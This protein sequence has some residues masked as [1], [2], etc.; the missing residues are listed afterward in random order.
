VD[1]KYL[2][3]PLRAA[4]GR[5]AA[6]LMLFRQKTSPDFQPN[7][8]TALK[9]IVAQISSAVLEPLIPAPPAR[10]EVKPEVKAVVAAQKPVAE[11][12]MPLD[13]RLRA[14]L[15]AGAFD[16]YAQP[17]AALHGAPRGGRFEV[18]VRMRD[19]DT[20]RMPRS[21]FGVA[22]A[23]GLLPDLDRCV[24]RQALQTLGSKRALLE[25]RGWEFSIN[26]SGQ[27]LLVDRFGE[28][29]EAQLTRSSVAPK[30]L[31]FEIAESSA[32]EHRYATEHLAARLR[33]LGCRLALDN[34]CAG[35][36]TFGPIRRWPVSCLKIDA[37]L[38][39]KIATDAHTAHVVGEVAEVASDIG[40]ETVGER[41]ERESVRSKLTELHID[42]AQGFLF[43]RP[44]PLAELLR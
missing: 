12:A 6:I 4:D 22:E 20:L 36:D 11:A 39:Q 8:V 9:P 10:T 19:A 13:R 34:C 16:L 28:F 17:I 41:V 33:D 31:V 38:T 32:L 26:L 37:S 35:L 42:F 1:Y 14:A 3:C 21:F 2:I 25:E 29:L 30:S 43:S 24:I 40:I 7:D 27:T 18:L 5:L 23:S 15:R 44:R